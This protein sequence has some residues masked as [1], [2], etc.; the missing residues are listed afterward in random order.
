MDDY[1]KQNIFL[2][3]LDTFMRKGF[4]EYDKFRSTY[5]SYVYNKHYAPIF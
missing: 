2:L 3:I 4:I 1:M 5:S